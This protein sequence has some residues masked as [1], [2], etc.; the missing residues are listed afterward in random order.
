MNGKRW[1]HENTRTLERMVRA[2]YS[3]MEIAAHTGHCRVT[4]SRRA[5]LLGLRPNR[6]LRKYLTRKVTIAAGAW[7]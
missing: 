4:V 2:G 3:H 6:M 5:S 1:T 7:T